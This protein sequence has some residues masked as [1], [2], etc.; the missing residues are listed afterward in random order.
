M[1]V[2]VIVIVVVV[3]VVVVVALPSDQS[4]PHWASADMSNKPQRPHNNP[5]LPSLQNSQLNDQ[6]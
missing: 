5:S 6:R 1:V 3:V 2:V 4:T